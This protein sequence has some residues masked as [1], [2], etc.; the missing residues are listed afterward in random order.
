GDA[1]ALVLLADHEAGDVLQK[2]ERDA[3]LIAD[4]DEVRRLERRLREEDAVVRQDPDL[5]AE[6]AREAGDDRRGVALLELL[7][8]RAIDDAGDDFAHV[9][10]AADVAR[11]HA[12]ELLRI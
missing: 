7:E 5:V 12:V 1:A 8:A 4:L 3:P 2:H 10:G 6:D 9:V 11:D